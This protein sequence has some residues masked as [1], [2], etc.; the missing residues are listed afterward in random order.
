MDIGK[1]YATLAV[2]MIH[3][4]AF[5]MSS[6]NNESF[7]YKIFVILNQLARFS[8][9]VFV[10]FSGIGL[11]LSYRKEKSLLNFYKKR[12]FKVIPPYILW[13]V[14]YLTLINKNF[15]YS[16]WPNL[17]LKGDKIFY[18]LYF[19]PMIIEL[20]LIFPVLYIVSQKIWG[21]ILTLIISGGI[22]TTG[23]YYNIPDLTL[24]F[25]SKRNIIFW[26][27]YFSLGIYFSGNIKASIEKLK[28]NK[29]L[30][31]GILL[32]CV[33]GIL[34]ESF[35][36]ISLG[37]SLDYATTFIRPSVIIY[38]I[39]FTAYILSRDYKKGMA[40]NIL[41]SISINS[42]DIYFSHPLVIYYY[43]K[44]FKYYK[45][46]IGSM[47]FILS[48]LILCT[49]LPILINSARRSI[50]SINLNKKKKN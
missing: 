42:F 39:I 5:A 36:S 26:L 19:L 18:H 37:K 8:V 9:P 15:N 10:I 21:V 47:E 3:V 44:V 29:T 13:G 4:S 41:K 43:M 22:I 28:R 27:F 50:F 38:S 31:I 20:Y 2:I 32:L 16:T 14:I 33:T 12:V 35:N 7:N 25:Y 24:D 30:I 45:M 17:F 11:G 40:V 1:A 46:D 23:H 34:W 48:S 6:S 49:T